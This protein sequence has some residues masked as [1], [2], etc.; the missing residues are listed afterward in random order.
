MLMMSDDSDSAIECDHHEP[1]HG[2][3]GVRRPT[4]F[5]RSIYIV[6]QIHKSVIHQLLDLSI[7]SDCM[8]WHTH[9]IHRVPGRSAGLLSTH[10]VFDDDVLRS[11]GM[12]RPIHSRDP[13]I[14][15]PVLEVGR[16]EM[17]EHLRYSIHASSCKFDTIS[18]VLQS[19]YQ[20][21]Q[22]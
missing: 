6:Y 22:Q 16:E 9:L 1:V 4:L 2:L 13:V 19:L 15:P 18:S 8:A 12:V 5:V 14:R 10:V 17:T 21:Q 7:L 3:C 11:K 20:H